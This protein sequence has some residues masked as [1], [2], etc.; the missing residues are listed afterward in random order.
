M[1]VVG[2]CWER[3]DDTII[4][5]ADQL[6]ARNSWVSELPVLSKVHLPR[7]VNRP[8]EHTVGITELHIFTDVSLRA[9]GVA[10]YVC[11]ESM[12]SHVRIT[13]L[14]LSKGQIAPLKLLSL[15][16]LELLACLTAARLYDSMRRGSRISMQQDRFSG[17]TPR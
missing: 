1:K 5:S 8:Q 10:A 14:L 11:S 13:H 3:S 9:Y 12:N 7:Q 17:P 4:V 15:P 6:T 2:L 16:R